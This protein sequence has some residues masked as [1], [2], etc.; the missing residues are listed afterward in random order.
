MVDTTDDN[1]FSGEIRVASR[2]IDYLSSGLYESPSA[3]LK[4]LINNSY[5]ADATEVEVFVKPDADRIIISDN[6]IGMNKEEFTRHFE[7]IAE[8]HK[9]D[10]TDKTPSGRFQI[11]KIGIGFIA[12]NELCKVLE[13]FSTKK[14]SDE[15]LHVTIDF[16]TMREPPEGRRRA[17]GDFAK[18]DYIGEVLSCDK[19]EHFTRIFLNEV[20]GAARP[21]LAGAQAQKEGGKARSLY[22]MSTKSVLE[23]L[24][25]PNLRTWD[26]FDRYSETMLEI[27]LNVPVPYQEGWL[28]GP[29][30]R[31][32]ADFENEVSS[33]GFQVFYDGVELRKPIVFDPRHKHSL[34]R[35]FKYAGSNVSARGYFYVQN[36][37]IKPLELH[38]L[39]VR[40]RQAA[41]GGYDPQFWDFS[42]SEASLMQRWVSAE[43]WADDKLE[44]AMNI[45]RRTLRVT[46]SSYVEL[47]DAI[48]KELRDVLKEA[49]AKIY[50]FGNIE[51]KSK[52]AHDTSQAIQTLARNKLAPVSNDAAK[53]MMSAWRKLE[54][55]PKP[56]KAFLRK[57]TVLEL[58]SLVVDV[59]KD[60]LTPSQLEKF[61]K[62]LTRR[63]TK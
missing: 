48:H 41:V 62:E 63:L 46:H 16:G 26:D 10:T 44:D 51:R 52:R 53:E 55:S 18:A 9:R 39:L 1:R 31:K 54:N 21:I 35:R 6:G 2:I 17:G 11:G 27:G 14:D 15:L 38:G 33:L 4:E 37:S 32:V 60:V 42:Q 36:T 8:S 34:I 12:A 3:C 50:E 22:G 47:R 23:A 29:L 7:R 57:F 61:V 56:H 59:A 49:R 40:I 5:D 58:Y 25:D 28:P 19:N 43:I 45:D 13:I 30:H 20:R 24:R